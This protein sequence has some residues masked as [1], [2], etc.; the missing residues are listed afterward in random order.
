MFINT[1]VNLQNFT[2]FS[3]GKTLVTSGSADN[4]NIFCARPT[5]GFSY[6]A[7]DGLGLYYDYTASYKRTRFYGSSTSASTYIVDSNTFVDL[8]LNCYTQNAAGSLSSFVY[9]S[10]TSNASAPART[11][12][13]QGFGVGT[14]FGSGVY[15]PSPTNNFQ[16][17]EIILYNSVLTTTQRQQIEGYLA[18]KWGLQK[19]LPSNHPFYLFPQG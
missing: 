2:V 5:S 19:S 9:G 14:E 11:T 6:N 17:C 1:A 10:N 15:A 3:I 18:W 13:T 16:I 8:V 4:Q 7:T 12:T